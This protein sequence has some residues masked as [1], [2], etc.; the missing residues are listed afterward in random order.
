M[1]CLR[2]LLAISPMFMLLAACAQLGSDGAGGTDGSSGAPDEIT[3]KI[4][5]GCRSSYDRTSHVE[6]P[7]EL[8]VAP[9]RIESHESFFAK[10]SAVAVFDEATIDLGQEIS[11]HGF[12]RVELVNLQATVYVRRGAKSVEGDEG[13]SV[14]LTIDSDQGRTC[15][16][17]ENGDTGPGAGPDFPPCSEENDN[18]DDESNSDCTGLGGIRDPENPCRVF[19]PIPW[20]DDCEPGGVC[21]SLPKPTSEEQCERNDF[22]VT[23]PVTVDLEGDFQELTAA[24][25]GSVLFGWDDREETTGATKRKEGGCNDGT[26]ELPPASADFDAAELGPN[27]MRI[28]IAGVIPLALECTMGVPSRF[29]D[30]VMSCDPLMSPTPDHR[31]IAFPIQER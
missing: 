19:V 23:G 15:T 6:L 12:K 21:L 29:E 7:W 28:V 20:S 30:G 4:L 18:P 27:A 9:S 26:W 3:K 10:L 11:P 2:F 1:P 22:C 5:L 16:Y 24:G 13:L 25:S 8:T 31:L 17:D 14:V